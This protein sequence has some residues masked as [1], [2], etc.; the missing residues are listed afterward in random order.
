MNDIFD[1]IY[2]KA[3]Q[4]ISFAQKLKR[5]YESSE[6][7]LNFCT[8]CGEYGFEITPGEIITMGEEYSCNQLKSTNG[9]GVIPY[10]Y[11]DDPY[12]M[13][14]SSVMSLFC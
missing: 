8:V 14:M 2:Q 6:P 11:F 10:D 7:L 9:G 4:D 1:K 5:A 13:L 3:R 12:E